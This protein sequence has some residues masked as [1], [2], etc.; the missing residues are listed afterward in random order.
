MTKPEKML[1]QEF[2]PDI[3]KASLRERWGWFGGGSGCWGGGLGEGGLVAGGG[4]GGRG[5]SCWGG[6]EGGL[7]VGGGLEGG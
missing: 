4:L 5:V 3:N 2:M 1:V 7:V 6:L